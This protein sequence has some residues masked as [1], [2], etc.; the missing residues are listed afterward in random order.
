MAEPAVPPAESVAEMP[1]PAEEAEVES[2][3]PP[4]GEGPVAEP[5]APESSIVP[6]SSLASAAVSSLTPLS[7]TGYCSNGHMEWSG[8]PTSEGEFPL[9]CRHCEELVPRP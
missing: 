9:T 6:E 3:V 2:P 8:G 5:P 7:N 4:Q 1:A